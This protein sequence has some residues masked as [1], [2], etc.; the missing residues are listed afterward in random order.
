MKL[1]ILSLVLV[2][3]IILMNVIP[4]SV[5]Y[6]ETIVRDVGASGSS[7]STNA[8]EYLKGV[9]NRVMLILGII[10]G[11]L[12]AAL[13]IFKVAIPYFSHDPQK[14]AQ[15][16]E[17]MMDATIATIIIAMAVGGMIWLIARWIA[18]V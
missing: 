17:N 7:S 18:G 12:V 4:G 8:S 2:L 15:A 10:A 13:W 14:K 1:G 3:G 16:K 9:A 6:G 11:V 5:V